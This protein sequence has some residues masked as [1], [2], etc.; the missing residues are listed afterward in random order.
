MSSTLAEDG[1]I[2]MSTIA[3]Y[4]EAKEVTL[5]LYESDRLIDAKKVAFE[6]DEVKPVYWKKISKD[7][8]HVQV[9]IANK[10]ILDLDNE[11]DVILSQS[12]KQKVLI[13]SDESFFLEKV[14]AAVG[15]YDIYKTTKEKASTQKGFDLYVYDGYVPEKNQEDGNIWLINPDKDYLDLGLKDGLKGTKLT[16]TD[17]LMGKSLSAYIKA[18]NIY[19]A[20]FKEA[21]PTD[22]WD[23]AFKCGQLPAIL[24]K[25]EGIQRHIVLLFSIE[26]SNLP[27]LKEFPILIQNML[28]IT[29][30]SLIEGDGNYI[31][32]QMLEVKG[33]INAEKIYLSD[34]SG[35]EISLAPPFPA[36]VYTI[37]KKGL[38]VL[39]QKLRQD[40]GLVDV[41][42]YFASRIAESESAMDQKGIN[43]D[44]SKIETKEIKAAL[45]MWP[46]LLAFAIL[47]GLLE[48]W[49]YYRGNKF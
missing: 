17:S 34:P 39:V 31:V 3:N 44:D 4:G 23:I 16:S 10:D 30:P 27:L 36:Q 5:E 38:Y 26:E 43:I 42:S 32:G 19:L 25:V 48:W 18:E 15:D 35:K 14:I 22:D 41:K 33:M 6:K 11:V 47:A 7:Y 40:G 8:K 29:L 49:V 28:S 45:E 21:K 46:Y 12:I 1:Y 24:T 37:D 2:L 13:V 9:R 20:R